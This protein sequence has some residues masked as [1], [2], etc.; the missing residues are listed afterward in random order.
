M[1]LTFDIVLGFRFTQ[2]SGGFIGSPRCNLWILSVFDHLP[3]SHFSI[4]VIDW[5]QV[6]QAE[7][8][9]GGVKSHSLYIS[10]PFPPS[11]LQG[12]LSF[13][14]PAAEVHRTRTPLPG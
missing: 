4:Q 12:N 1:S 6:K 9:P 7:D 13:L 11:L 8:V 14:S 2:L 5:F 3:V 10:L